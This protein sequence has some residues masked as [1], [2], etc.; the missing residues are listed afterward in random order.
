MAQP[1]KHGIIA[2]SR[3]PSPSPAAESRR[4]HRELDTD[5]AG[6][7]WSRDRYPVALAFNLAAFLLPALYST[8]AKLWVAKIDSS[9]VVTTDVYTYIGTIAEVINEGLPR[10]SWAIIGD[11]YSRNRNNRLALAHTLIFAQT[12]LGL[13]LSV[14]LL[15][16]AETFAKGFV[17][18]E[19]RQQS[20][21]YV[22]ISSFSALS[23]AIEAAVASA[24][25]ALDQPD[26]ALIVS[27]VKFVVNIVLDLLLISTVRVGSI[28]PTVNMQAGIQL[29]CNLA[30]ALGGLSY[31]L[32]K[33]SVKLRKET[34]PSANSAAPSFSALKILLRPAF[35]TFAES[36]VRNTFYLWLVTTIVSM[37]SVY[38]TAWGVF[39]TIRW[40]LVMV[41]VSALEATTLTFVGHS[42]SRWRREIGV[43]TL[44]PRASLVSLYR[45][46]RL[47]FVSAAI[48]LSFELP[49]CIA[50]YFV[51]AYPFARYLSGRDEVAAVTARMWR[52]LDW[53]YLAYAISTQ[54]SAILLATR[55]KWYLWQSLASTLLYVMP[56]AI[57]C[58]VANLNRDNAWTYHAL[59]FGGSLVFSFVCVVSVLGLWAWTLMTGRAHLEV[60][61]VSPDQSP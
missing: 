52:T 42:W 1:R 2:T 32:F 44:R 19:V 3:E 10:V 50:M 58:Q 36:A 13:A 53:C 39:N 43:S 54:M 26:V 49:L 15:G 47:A 11:K 27:I 22:R 29:A 9:M 20:I 7:R 28:K 40:G 59:V 46:T 57:V 6:S 38:A 45:I 24:T 14:A 35:P 12:T 21:T 60:V 18:Q 31:F 41:P 17:P 33:N 16:A 25:R 8:L 56:W 51:G 37:G 4:R 48:A 5:S 61:R 30:A 55:P 23:S 34:N